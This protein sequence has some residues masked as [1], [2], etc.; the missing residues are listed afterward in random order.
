MSRTVHCHISGLLQ[1][2]CI[3]GTSPFLTCIASIHGVCLNVGDDFSMP[4]N[5]TYY[6]NVREE[7]PSGTVVFCSGSLQIA[8]SSDDDPHLSIKA[9]FLIR[10]VINI[11]FVFT[12]LTDLYQVSG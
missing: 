8:E 6:N 2:D 11:V 9:H 4:V 10:F 3:L 7:F 12:R 1:L 5:L